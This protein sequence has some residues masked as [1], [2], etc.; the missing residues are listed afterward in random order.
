MLK[1]LCFQEDVSGAGHVVAASAGAYFHIDFLLR[2]GKR[3]EF[4]LE[5]V[6]TV[7]VV[8]PKKTLTGDNAE[9]IDTRVLQLIYRFTDANPGVLPGQV[10]DVYVETGPS[11]AEIG[12]AH[13]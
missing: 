5:Y 3:V 11:E 7:P 10:L 1:W 13:V 9:R 4:P 2:G 8:I 6:R 12:R